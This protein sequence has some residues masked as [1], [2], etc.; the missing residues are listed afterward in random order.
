MTGAGLLH[1][2]DG[3]AGTNPNIFARHN[4]NNGEKGYHR[5]DIKYPEVCA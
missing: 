5:R 2:T 4:N 1:G 3:L